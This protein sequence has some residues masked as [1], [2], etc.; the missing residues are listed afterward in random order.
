MPALSYKTVPFWTKRQVWEQDS[1][2]NGETRHS[3]EEEGVG[4]WGGRENIPGTN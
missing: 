1:D 2:G 4:G 3:E